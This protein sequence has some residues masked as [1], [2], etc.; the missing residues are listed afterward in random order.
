MRQQRSLTGSLRVISAVEW[1]AIQI[2]RSN[3]FDIAEHGRANRAN[4]AA[5]ARL[6]T[7]HFAKGQPYPIPLSS[8]VHITSQES[9]YG[10]ASPVAH[11]LRLLLPRFDS[12]ERGTGVIQDKVEEQLLWLEPGM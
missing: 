2:T 4:P 3:L 10:V 8:A 1:R 7:R 11:P 9:D 12:D 6:Q 5:S